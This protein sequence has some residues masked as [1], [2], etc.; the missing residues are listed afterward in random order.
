MQRSVLIRMVAIGTDRLDRQRQPM[1]SSQVRTSSSPHGM[2][3]ESRRGATSECR[4]PQP[5]RVFFVCGVLASEV[6][7][8]ERV[9][10]DPDRA[11]ARTTCCVGSKGACPRS[12]ACVTRPRLA[13]DEHRVD[14]S[15]HEAVLGV[16]VEELGRFSRPLN[17]VAPC[18]RS[19]CMPVPTQ[20]RRR[21]KTLYSRYRSP[22]W[23]SGRRLATHGKRNNHR[24]EHGAE[25]EVECCPAPS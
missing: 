23:S 25:G 20:S 13:A 10:Y 9:R 16:V 12:R 2:Q 5:R 4:V 15:V 1:M 11:G 6:S 22:N 24:N 3:D 21:R 14:C 19:R 18:G 7:R 8:L 17:L